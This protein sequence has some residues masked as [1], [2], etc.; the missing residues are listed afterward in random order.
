MRIITILFMLFMLFV[1]VGL[2]A[3]GYKKKVI[4]G[5][6]SKG[7]KAKPCKGIADEAAGCYACA[8]SKIWDEGTN[9]CESRCKQ[10]P[11]LYWD[12]KEKKC[13]TYVQARVAGVSLQYTPTTNV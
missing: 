9:R 1:V 6:R 10:A 5:K 4:E 11:A 3:V 12:D 2:A 8:P 13:L 7:V